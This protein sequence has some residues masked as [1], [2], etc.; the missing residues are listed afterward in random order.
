VVAAA[1]AGL[2]WLGQERAGA[3]HAVPSVLAW[4]R[5]ILYALGYHLGLACFVQP[6]L[7]K[8]IP[9]A[10]PPSFDPAVDLFP[11]GMGLL[12]FIWLRRRRER[13][14][15]GRGLLFAA[16]AYLPSSGI[17]PLTRYLADSYVYLPLAGLAWLVGDGAESLLPAMRPAVRWAVGAGVG[18]CLLVASS[19]TALAWT[20]GIALWKTVYQRYP[21]SPQVCLNLGNAYFERGRHRTALKIYEHCSGQFGPGH[22][23]KNRAIALFMVGRRTEARQLFGELVRESPDDPGLRKYLRWLDGEPL[24]AAPADATGSLLESW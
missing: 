17:V 1:V 23:A 13:P 11:I 2:S 22:F 19:A 7:A 15:A 4:A 18:L 24:P 12:L 10:M 21:D 16:L 14:A 3:V 9:A 20:D 6:P 8:H 5:E